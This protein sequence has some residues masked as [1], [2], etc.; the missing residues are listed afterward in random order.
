M[1]ENENPIKN[2]VW[3]DY[4]SFDSLTLLQANYSGIGLIRRALFILDHDVELAGTILPRL[5]EIATESCSTASII[6][7][8]I[9]YSEKLLDT[10]LIV[11]K[12]W[13]HKHLADSELELQSLIHKIDRPQPINILTQKSE[14]CISSA[15]AHLFM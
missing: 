14:V 9:E 3:L 1:T 13:Y 6:S 10:P 5:L 7:E 8:I 4:L 12:E 15:T 2:N 11:D